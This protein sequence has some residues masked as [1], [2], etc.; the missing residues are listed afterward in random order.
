MITYFKSHFLLSDSFLGY[1]ALALVLAAVSFLIYR[2]ALPKPIPGIPYDKKVAR[3]IF[4]NL[5]E[6]ISWQKVHGRPILYMTDYCRHLGS[7]LAQ[8]WL[9]PLR[10]PALVLTDFTEIE[11][12]TQ[13]RAKEFGRDRDFTQPFRYVVPEF[14]VTLEKEDPRYSANK[15]LLKDTIVRPS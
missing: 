6:L 8:V 13:R 3:S 4:G 1:A 14:H 15:D 5:P 12:V 7:P 11:N 9:C 2:W 10:K